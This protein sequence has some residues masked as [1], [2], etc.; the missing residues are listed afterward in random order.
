MSSPSKE[1]RMLARIVKDDPRSTTHKNLKYLSQMTGME[2]VENFA[3]W[4]VKEALG[5]KEV[6]QNE[7]WRL[8]LL[9]TLLNMKM[10]KYIQVHY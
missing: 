6:P 3:S 7:K 1:V 10:D 4:K 9:A 8:R 5:K 2:Q